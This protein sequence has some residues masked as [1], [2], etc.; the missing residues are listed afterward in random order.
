MTL[1]LFSNYSKKFFLKKKLHISLL[2]RIIL[3]GYSEFRVS[4]EGVISHHKIDRVMPVQK[5]RSRVGGVL[6]QPLD[7]LHKEPLTQN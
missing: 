7:L 6:G 4:S 1:Y 2:G 3:D 5:E